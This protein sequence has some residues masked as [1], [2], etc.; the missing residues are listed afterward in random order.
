MGV[1]DD[2][3]GLRGEQ[4]RDFCRALTADPDEAERIAAQAS[5]A[6][7]SRK[8]RS[9]QLTADAAVWRT[10]AEVFIASRTNA[11]AAEVRVVHAL[12]DVQDLEV[13]DI[14]AL[15]DKRHRWVTRRLSESPGVRE[16]AAPTRARRRTRIL[17]LLVVVLVAAA[18]ALAWQNQK[19]DRLEA[20][21]TPSVLGLLKW[22]AR[23]PL[24]RDHQLHVAA[25]KAWRAQESTLGKT[26][27]LWAGRRAGGRLVVLQGMAVGRP[28]V[29]VVGDAGHGL[30]LLRTDT[31]RPGW[32]LILVNYAGPSASAPTVDGADPTVLQALLEPGQDL[33][34]IRGARINRGSYAEPYG[35]PATI[36]RWRSL[37]ITDGLSSSWLD[38]SSV[39]P[40]TAVKVGPR[41]KPYVVLGEPVLSQVSLGE[42][43][44]PAAGG[45]K[46]DKESI[47]DATLALAQTLRQQQLISRLAY[48]IDNTYYIELDTT[49]EH[50]CCMG[51]AVYELTHAGD[52]PTGQGFELKADYAAVTPKGSVIVQRAGE[53]TLMG[54]AGSAACAF[55][56]K[57]PTPVD[58]DIA[59]VYADPLTTD[60]ITEGYTG[61]FICVDARGRVVD[62]GRAGRDPLQDILT[63]LDGTPG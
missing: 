19:T 47:D 55:G 53:I 32:P 22:P 7:D 12:R 33:V 20:R 4:L 38:F 39:A 24:G 50:R 40:L 15:L 16:A 42:L 21:D 41:G 14:A 43:D 31:I 2:A 18:A 63:P 9:G 60:S 44:G 46:T 45:V 8:V 52:D 6:A 36:G 57:A 29:A 25:Q 13:A 35:G 61:A 28:E 49:G 59:A 23:G 30:K 51:N 37:D 56:N 10:A 34:Q 5:A 3:V 27:V 11:R 54:A 62:K 48:F 58:P 1:L 17:V 26:W